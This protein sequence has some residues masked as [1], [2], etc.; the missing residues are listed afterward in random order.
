MPQLVKARKI[1]LFDKVG[2][3]TGNMTYGIIFQ[4]I[5]TYIV[6]YA[7]AVLGIPGG[8]IGTV[9]SLT[10]LWDAVSDPMMGYISDI[11]RSKRYGRRH[12]Y[13]LIGTLS[14]AVFNFFLWDV[15]PAWPQM[16]KYL[17]VFAGLFLVRTALTIFLTPF[18]ALGAELT[19]DYDER[20][21]IQG[22]RMIFFI[23]GLMGATVMGFLLFFNPTPEYPVGQLN[24]N[25]YR[26]MG[27]TVSIIALISGLVSYFTT[28]KY[29]PDLPVFTKDKMEVS[30]LKNL[31]SSFKLAMM[32][33]QYRFIVM[34]YLFTNIA[35]AIISAIGIHVFTYTFSLNNTQIGIVFGSL[36]GV[37]ILSQP[38]W[39]KISEKID[40]KPAAVLG[41]L[42]SI[43][44]SLVFFVLVMLREHIQGQISFLIL[45]AVITGFGAGALFS[46][47]FSMIADTIDFDELQ[48]GKRMEGVYY[49]T[50]TLFY[51]FSQSIAIFML[52]ILLDIVKFDSSVDKQ[53]EST[54]LALGLTL[55]IGS[56]IVLSLAGI[57]YS[58]YS[59][60]K[61][62]ISKVQENIRNK[63]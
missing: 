60:N 3:G 35:T 34:A 10:V 20:T 56:I 59:L 7:T 30:G 42:F 47:P 1:P 21:S 23:L 36:F 49:G 24:P 63:N 50:L 2:Y 43:A 45:F 14:M 9:V 31:I 27:L 28:K 29:I 39:V 62:S 26:N 51:K 57:S 19:S 33:R 32:N 40:K 12:I 5:G 58:K 54:I 18:T 11:T 15:D 6:F 44:G 52:G 22:I 55:S 48:T 13:I 17:M 8:V 25:A 61:S 37:S 53:P 4:M 38:V 46:L 16:V 41:I